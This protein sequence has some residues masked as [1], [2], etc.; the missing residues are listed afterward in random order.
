MLGGCTGSRRDSNGLIGNPAAVAETFGS[1]GGLGVWGRWAWKVVHSLHRVVGAEAY[2]GALQGHMWVILALGVMKGLRSDKNGTAM[3]MRC[4][5]VAEARGRDP[6]KSGDRAGDLRRIAGMPRIRAAL[7][8]LT[9]TPQTKHGW[10]DMA[11]RLS[12]RLLG[13]LVSHRQP[14]SCVVRA[15]LSTLSLHSNAFAKRGIT[16]VD[17]GTC[18]TF[19]RLPSKRSSWYA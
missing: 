19:R 18:L 4:Q 10:M 13:Q 5:C 15:P 17:H 14:P 2:L 6:K 1:G 9:S 8:D 3:M 12:S 11:S 7:L 16:I